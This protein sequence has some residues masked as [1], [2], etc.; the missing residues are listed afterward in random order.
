MS[1]T[2]QYTTFSDLYNGLLNATRQDTGASATVAQAK[3]YI[4]I[5]LV[6]MHVG[7]GEKF[8]WAERNSVLFTQPVYSD[9]LISIQQGANAFTGVSTLWA[10]QLQQTGRNNVNVGG[11][12]VIKG[13]EEVYE[14]LTAPS[15]T[16]GTLTSIYIGESLAGV[17][18]DTY[19]YFEDEYALASDFLRPIDYRRFT[20]GH[21]GIDL[22][23]RSDFRR[24]FGSNDIPGRPKQAT[25]IDL[26]PSGNTTPRRRIVFSPPPDVAYQLKYSYVTSNLVT[27]S[28]GTA[29]V[30]LSADA[31]EPI[32]PPRYRHVI[33]LHALYNWYRDKKDDDRAQEARAEY[34]DLVSRIAADNEI[35]SQNTRIQP[36][37]SP[38]KSRARRPWGGGKRGRFDFDNRFDRMEW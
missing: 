33:L 21:R 29:Q 19:R 18:G 37:Q 23:G 1:A 32:V 16:S 20:S 30:S 13:Q 3:R 26:A 27:A 8:P 36:R 24:R 31:D 17:A 35:G 22:V 9:G 38:Y 28:D 4:N 34:I 12:F 11:K 14:I 7:F 5:G 15:D 2:T 6:D 25:I 10:T